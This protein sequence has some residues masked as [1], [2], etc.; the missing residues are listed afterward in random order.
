MAASTIPVATVSSAATLPEII[1]E[2]IGQLER[3][4]CGEAFTGGLNPAQW[5]ALRYFQRANRFS[6]SVGAFARYHGTTMGTASQTV[7]ALVVKGLLCRQRVPGDRRTVRLDLTEAAVSVLTQDPFRILVAAADTLPEPGQAA[8]AAGLEDMLK[9]VLTAQGRPHF[10]LCSA[11][12]YLR[13]APARPAA[14]PI[15]E[16]THHC[17]LMDEPLSTVETAQLCVNCRDMAPPP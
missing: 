11:C 10:G 6:R 4:A 2:L 1:A 17:G 13:D 5:S 15:P 7:K 9:Q 3:C 16:E 12:C 14:G 8:V